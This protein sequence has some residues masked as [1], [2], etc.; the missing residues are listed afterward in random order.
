[1]VTK[2]NAGA[3]PHIRQRVLTPSYRMELPGHSRVTSEDY[4]SET[5]TVVGNYEPECV[6]T[7]QQNRFL[8]L[9][10]IYDRHIR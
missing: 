2:M 3:K 7:Q 4:V 8:N 5:C 10:G 9:T 1:M 6:S